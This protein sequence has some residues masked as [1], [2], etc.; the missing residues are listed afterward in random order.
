M[1][2]CPLRSHD[3]YTPPQSEA[4]LY[5]QLRDVAEETGAFLSE[6][7]L[8]LIEELADAVFDDLRR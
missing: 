5:A 3:G 1:P 7:T 8:T 6:S 2:Q 4:D